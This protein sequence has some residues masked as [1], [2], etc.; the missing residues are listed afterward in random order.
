MSRL[1]VVTPRANTQICN[2]AIWWSENRSSIQAA[3]WL[4]QIESAISG[5]AVSAERHPLAKESDKFDFE[6]R[7]LV[8]GISGKRTHRILFSIHDH[9]VV[10]YAVRH[11]AQQDVT[12]V[13]LE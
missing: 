6:L 9:Q 11:L 10:V 7:Q 1:V 12:S 8:F 4:T 13:D 2:N 5:L 3:Q